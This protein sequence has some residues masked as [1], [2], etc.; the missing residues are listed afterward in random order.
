MLMFVIVMA[1]PREP[2]VAYF[3][4]THSGAAIAF[5][6]RVKSLNVIHLGPRQFFIYQD[7]SR[8][9]LSELMAQPVRASLRAC[10]SL[11]HHGFKTW[12]QH[13]T[14]YTTINFI[15]Y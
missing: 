15:Q 10:A 6:E 8:S 4:A 12:L 1:T 11:Q 9:N 14:F 3:R 7:K 2:P 13:D 5:L